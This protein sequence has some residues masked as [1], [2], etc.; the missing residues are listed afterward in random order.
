MTVAYSVRATCT[1]RGGGSGGGR[2]G[3]GGGGRGGPPAIFSANVPA[4]IDPQVASS[5]D[6]LVASFSR[7]AVRNVRPLRP[8]YGTAGRAIAVR[9]NFFP[10]RLSDGPIYDY[11]VNILPKTDINRL[12]AR[13]F[14]L[15]ETSPAFIPYVGH[16]AHDGSARLVS[17][18]PLPQPLEVSI[19]FLDEGQTIP[20]PKAK[21][22]TIS[23]K[24]TAVLDPQE[25][26]R[27]L[28][29]SAGSRDY[30][31]MPLIG[32][33]NLVMQQHAARNGVRVGRNRHFFPPL[34]QEQHFYLGP[35]VEALRG[36]FSSVRPTIG[37]LAVNVNVCMTAFYSPGNMVDVLNAFKGRGQGL[38]NLPRT[39]ARGIKVTT[40]HLGH[41]RKKPLKGIGSRTARKEIFECQELGGRVSV[42]QYFKRKYNITLKHADDL[43][44]IDIGSKAKS[45]FI[46][47]ELCT[48]EPDVPYLQKLND[49]ETRE[50]IRI[51]C[52]PPAFNAEKIVNDGFT[53]L[54]LTQQTRPAHLNGFGIEVSSEMLVVPARELPPPGLSYKVGRTQARDGSWNILDVQFHKPAKVDSW[55]VLVVRDGQVPFAQGPQDPQLQG[56][57][58]GFATK[59]RKSGMS[60]PQALPNLLVTDPLPPE[61]QDPARLRALGLIKQ[62]INTELSKSP[63]PSFILVLLSKRDNFIYPG[64]KRIGDVELGIHTLHMQTSKALGDPRKQDQYFSNVALK[65]NTKLGGHNH[66]LDGRAMQWLTKVKTM[67]VGID[68][69]H[70]GPG[71]IE[72]TPSIAAVVA[73]VDHQFVQFPASLRVQQSKKEMLDELRD[74]LVE[75]LRLFES[76]NK[77]LPDRILIF[78]DGVSEGQYDTV[79]QEELAQIF[80]AFQRLGTAGR[81]VYR[82]KLS[83]IICGKRHHARFYPTTSA[84][85][86]KNG[87]TK[88]GT[89]VD[90][91]VTSVFDY[92]FYLQAHSGLQGQ[93]RPTHY[94]IIYDENGLGADEIQV[95]AHDFSYLYAR[96]TKAVS[97]IPA[98]YYADLACERGRCYINDFLTDDK[99]S[100]SGTKKSDRDEERAR[101][102]DAAKKRWGE[103]VHSSL[104]ETLPCFRVAFPY[105]SEG[106]LRDDSPS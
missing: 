46:P 13:I 69:T 82:P 79:L 87:N 35:G 86:S 80:E 16:I 60:I 41:K 75:R 70:P 97:L 3:G 8:G 73:S 40:T 56:L 42:E 29:G 26:K 47:A 37:G 19:T 18:Q 5:E 32:A 68:V 95:G 106:V 28:E 43:P 85:A 11:Q 63:R 64:I 31:P 22:Y 24:Q 77:G 78:R 104:R 27:Q 61:N 14:R 39:F 66:L 76:R 91:G 102:F 10:L 33:L 72:G 1:A 84:E 67:M 21:R 54:G 15:L 9:A 57:V 100:L 58:S 30:D 105:L 59:L 88:P 44:V 12:K 2:G 36:F 89:V 45:N 65:V 103:G 53:K 94:V 71:S 50:M 38:P 62:R 25:L 17:A 6:K 52:N 98:A 99:T 7:L 51:A 23:I 81:K 90:R 92:D 49:N 48:I 83:I 4:R 74:M 101:V 96:A 20:S 34:P 55:W 93:V